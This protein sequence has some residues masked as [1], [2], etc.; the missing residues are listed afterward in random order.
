MSSFVERNVQGLGP[1][2][3]RNNRV[4]GDFQLAL[5]ELQNVLFVFGNQNVAHGLCVFS[6]S[7]GAS[8]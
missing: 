3:H 1:C 5:D 4:P 7:Y 2:A 6:P 8:T